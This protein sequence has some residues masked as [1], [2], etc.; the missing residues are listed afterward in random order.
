MPGM[1][2]KTMVYLG[3]KDDDDGYEYDYDEL[4]LDDE[5]YADAHAEPLERTVRPERYERAERY[6]PERHA[7]YEPPPRHETVSRVERDS[8]SVT[9]QPRIRALPADEVVGRESSTPT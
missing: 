7:R 3:L 8:V 5:Q 9:P 2:Q 4:V 1:W 6:V